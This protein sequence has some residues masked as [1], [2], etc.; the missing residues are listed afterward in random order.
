MATTDKN[1]VIVELYDLTLTERKDDRFGRVVI[2]SVFDVTSGETNSRLMPGGAVNIAGTK[3]KIAADNAANDITLTNYANN[4]VTVIATTAIAVND[5]M[6]VTFVMP[7]HT[8][9]ERAAHL[10]V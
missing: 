6:K 2:N 4:E 9:L 3:I 8:N 7:I 1:S 10:Y 5:S